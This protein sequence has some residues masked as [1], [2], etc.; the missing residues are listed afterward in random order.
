M[1]ALGPPAL[2]PTNLRRLLSPAEQA[3]AP[4]VPE[5]ETFECI[6]I[7]VDFN[8]HTALHN[9]AVV[10]FATSGDTVKV[11]GLNSNPTM[12]VDLARDAVYEH[13]D[14]LL[15][16]QRFANTKIVFLIEANLGSYPAQFARLAR[17]KYA[18]RCDTLLWY[19]TRHCP[20]VYVEYA[21]YML[22]RNRVT[23]DCNLVA[24]APPDGDEYEADVLKGVLWAQLLQLRKGDIVPM[25]VDDPPPNPIYTITTGGKDE[26]ANA[27]LFGLYA[28]ETYVNRE[29]ARS[30]LALA[31]EDTT[32][33]VTLI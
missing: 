9:W 33:Q 10:S 16:Q 7:A 2:D 30:P 5:P 12:P 17:A 25:P 21:R 28:I 31:A 3:A 8:P 26:L 22:A 18:A 13:V 24:C 6:Y 23:I 19:T 14:A 1:T 29:Q 32:P 27:F 11:V 15:A 4:A 20:W